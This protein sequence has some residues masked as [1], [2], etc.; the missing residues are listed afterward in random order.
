MIEWVDP[1]RSSHFLKIYFIM[2]KRIKKRFDIDVTTANTIHSKDFEL[3]KNITAIHG[4]LIASG[5]DD[6]LYYRGSQKIEINRE[7][8]FP[9]GYESKLLMTGINLSPNDRYYTLGG[10]PPGNG[11]V[12]VSYKDTDYA[13]LAFAAYRVSIYLDCETTDQP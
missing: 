4:L 10:K 9:E 13:G 5:R 11:K 3:D 6:L 8:I 7:E 2:P 12:T 1:V